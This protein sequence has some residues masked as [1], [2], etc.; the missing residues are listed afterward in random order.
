MVGLPSWFEIWYGIRSG[1]LIGVCVRYRSLF[2]LQVRRLG[3]LA[4]AGTGMGICQDWKL[5]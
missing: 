5:N 4:G 2:V 3:G 1:Q